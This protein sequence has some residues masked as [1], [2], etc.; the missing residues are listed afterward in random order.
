MYEVAKKHKC[1]DQFAELFTES[2]DDLEKLISLF[3][4]KKHNVEKIN[5]IVI[6]IHKEESAADEVYI[7]TI[8]E[9][10]KSEK[11]AVELIKWKEIVES[12]ENIS[13]TFKNVTDT[14]VNA[15]MKNG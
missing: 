6:S 10:F 12:L 4:E 2:A 13:D 15:L 11:N 5:K 14:V 8:K 9:L 3:F 7:N 1:I